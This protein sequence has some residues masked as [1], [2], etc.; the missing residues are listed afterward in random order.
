MDLVESIEIGLP[1]LER[2]KSRHWMATFHETK[3]MANSNFFLRKAGRRDAALDLIVEG[4]GQIEN[5]KE[6]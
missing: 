6:K 1:Y 4:K 5:D 3:F 2:Q